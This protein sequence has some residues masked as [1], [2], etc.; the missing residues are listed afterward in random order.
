MLF[1]LLRLWLWHTLLGPAVLFERDIFGKKKRK[2]KRKEKRKTR[3][4]LSKAS[5]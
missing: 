5:L 1:G 3:V 2:K 4:P